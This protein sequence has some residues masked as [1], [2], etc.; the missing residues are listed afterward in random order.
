[1]KQP[2]NSK[3]QMKI[4]AVYLAVLFILAAADFFIHKHTETSLE[5]LPLFYVIFSI[6]TGAA[7]VVMALTLR[8][9][10]SR[11]ERYYE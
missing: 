3:K 1:M 5:G 4:L 9:F 11:D 10:F 8:L 6:I 7:M 2:D